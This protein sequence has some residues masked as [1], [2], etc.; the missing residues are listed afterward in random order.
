MAT[1]ARVCKLVGITEFYE[2]FASEDMKAV[3]EIMEKGEGVKVYGGVGADGA[4]QEGKN[5]DEE[6]G[7]DFGEV[8][9]R[10]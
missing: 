10:D 3:L 6:E 5:Y 7:E 2:E 9:E 4:A 1:V 8:L